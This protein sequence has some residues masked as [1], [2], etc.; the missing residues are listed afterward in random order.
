M[1]L[2]DAVGHKRWPALL[3]PGLWLSRLL[4]ES[5]LTGWRAI[6]LLP[7]ALT[8]ALIGVGIVAL[9]QRRQVDCRSLA[10][11][12]VYVFWP[13]SARWGGLV[14]GALALGILLIGQGPRWRREW[15]LP[16]GV[17]LGALTLYVATLSPGLLPAD[18]GEFQLVGAV[19]GIAHPPGYALYTMLAKL[20]TLLLPIG[21][22]A[23]RVNLFAALTSA[24]TLA[25]LAHAVQWR[26][27]STAAAVL[28]CLV[29]GLS[30]TFWVQS[31]TAN[32]RS[33]TLLFEMAT[34]VAL[35][36]WQEGREAR[37]LTLAALA[38]GL[39]VAHHASLAFLAIPLAV[40][41]LWV[42]PGIWR[43]PRRWAGPA[44]ALIAAFAVW[45][46]LPIRSAM[47]SA[48]DPNPISTLRAFREHVMASGFR[49][50]MFAYRAWPILLGRARVYWDILALQFGA[51]M[52]LASLLAAMPLLRK[53]P[54]LATM[55]LG[56]WAINSLVAISY[57]APQTVEYLL[58]AYLALAALLGFGA[59][60]LCES[61]QRRTVAATLLAL[62]LLLAGTH[63]LSNR[64]SLLSLHEDDST[65]QT[66]EAL[67]DTAPPDALILANWHQATPLWYLQIVEGRRPDVEVTYVYP[68][69][70]TANET[71][72]L[73]RIDEAIGERPVIVTNRYHGFAHRDY[74]WQT[75]S[76]GWQVHDRPLVDTPVDMQPLAATFGDEITI[77]G[78]QVSGQTVAPAQTIRVSVYWQAGEML[79]DN[80][81][82][83]C[84]IVGP[85]GAI[86]QGDLGQSA[87]FEGVR[88]DSYELSLLP[89]T[90]TG[91]CQVITGF[92]TRQDVGW[93][94][95]LNADGADH[96]VLSS[97][98]VVAGDEP[99]PTLH[100]QQ[101]VYAGGLEWVGYDVDCSLPG[102]TRLYLHWRQRPEV[103]TLGPWRAKGQ[104]VSAQ[105]W[106]DGQLLAQADVPPLDDGQTATIALD[107]PTV[108]QVA[109][110]LVTPDGAIHPR[111][112]A[113][114]RHSGRD[115]SLDLPIAG[116][117]YIP[118]GG[119]MVFCGLEQA[120]ERIEAGT[121][122]T[123]VP[124][125]LSSRA[126]TQDYSVSLGLRAADGNWE[127]KSDGT[128]ALGAIPTLKWLQ[129]WLLRDPRS[130]TVPDVARGSEA[131]VTLEVYDAFSLRPLAVLDERR[132][133]QGQ[134][135]T[136]QLG[137]VA[138]E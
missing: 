64:P 56:I 40:F 51:P 65:R 91:V 10:L 34:I 9:L 80:L 61:L 101:V 39:G 15:L 28:A 115:L 112:V 73:R 67:L 77:L 94:R 57:R 4:V 70:A 2:L 72:W 114:N 117:A 83:F 96:L 32:V 6:W 42:E 62:L 41:V 118:L 12:W 44:L 49:G 38:F 23:Y 37:W 76:G 63:G 124:Q 81:S 100:P 78:Y 99:A 131:V 110:R 132:V 89:Q 1:T 30:A 79:P 60:S 103:L 107:L 16:L 13:S 35:L 138:V 58:P 85:E 55:L 127:V 22:P 75:L 92:Y 87:S 95:L 26:T 3:L 82:S 69:G 134:G 136:L 133:Q 50:D 17:F 113:W 47:Q 90:P 48:F 45:L 5:S 31:T 53:R 105:V 54:R 43:Q 71:V 86:A 46:Y 126:L 24:A 36:H 121:E 108:G 7:L 29:L 27:R 111:L 93:Q 109:L 74:Q 68:E 129:G 116:S 19:L 20:T 11:L 88:V 128:P 125:F 119:E 25:M 130:V 102:Q 18:A 104:A 33:L 98:E 66:A 106:S 84:Q 122:A 52:L 123:L 8:G 97:V 14:L 120:P 137:T 135:V 21:S 59:A